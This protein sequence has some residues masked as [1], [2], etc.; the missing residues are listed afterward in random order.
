M[1]IL[2]GQTTILSLLM[3]TGGAILLY[4]G[5]E[6]LVSGSSSLAVRIG[7]TPLVVGLT[8]VAFGTS[9][10]ELVVSLSAALRDNPEIALGNVIGSNVCNIALILGVASLIRPIEVELRF[11][12]SDMLIMIGVSILMIL[13][14][15]DGELSLYDGIIFAIGIVLYN[16][17]AIYFTRRRKAKEI[18]DGMA[19]DIET[20][21]NPWLDITMIIG[22]LGILVVGANLFLQGA[23]QIA[24]TLGA[25]KALVGL[26]IVALGTSLPE[27]ATSVV[28][29]I[30]KEGDISIGNAIGSNIYNILCILGFTA[31]VNPIS[32]NGISHIDMGVML[33][34][35]ILIY[36]LARIGLS[37]GRI[38]GAF[39]LLI[40][41]S[42]MA[43]LYN[44]LLN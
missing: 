10:P 36:P 35:S 2:A 12:K 24:E 28:A 29:A 30:K 26:T 38:K 37:I 32:T 19:D 16:F 3:L 8:V 44:Q 5:A 11:L 17:L 14:A 25:S 43:Y 15:L 33:L 23:I 4:L 27:L 21:R 41:L 18:A 42:Y 7:I 6:G 40:Y 1:E 13:L 20:K 34:I 39:L 9:S 31:I 22:G